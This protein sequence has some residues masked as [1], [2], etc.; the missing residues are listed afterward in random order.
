MAS[1][2]WYEVTPERL[3]LENIRVKALFPN[4]G[5]VCI[6]GV[7]QWHGSVSEF[8]PGLQAVPLNILIEYPPAFPA[9]P[10]QVR[11]LNSEIGSHEVGHQWHR[12]FNGNICFIRPR[13]WQISTTT[14]EII[15]KVEDWYFNYLASKAGLIANMP[16]TG[17][18]NIPPLTEGL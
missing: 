5:L 16:D 3:V 12:W 14:D 4:F 9:S 11:L 7:L 1:K 15:S 6:E 17:R 10:P 18:A 8:P 2:F 13:Y